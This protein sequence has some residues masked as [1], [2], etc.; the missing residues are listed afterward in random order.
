MYVLV[1]ILFKFWKW[2]LVLSRWT[3]SPLKCF[4][5]FS[6][7]C[8]LIM[9]FKSSNISRRE[10]CLLLLARRLG[11]LHAE[12]FRSY[13][14]SYYFSLTTPPIPLVFFFLHF[15]LPTKNPSSYIF[16]HFTTFFILSH[17]GL[18]FFSF[19]HLPLFL[20]HLSQFL[21]SPFEICYG[22]LNVRLVKCALIKFV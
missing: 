7:Q 10:C 3:S 21:L 8:K 14:E 18:L 9:T 17:I 22:I 19:S 4:K 16:S 1:R 20:H 12:N 13:K 15:I 5:L 11:L 6:S 2:D